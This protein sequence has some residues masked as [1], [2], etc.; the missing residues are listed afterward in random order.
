ML[1]MD[2]TSRAV[3]KDDI[4]LLRI[5][6]RRN[7]TVPENVMHHSLAAAIFPRTIIW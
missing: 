1:I 6:D 7:F 4:D 3:A 5:D 2:K